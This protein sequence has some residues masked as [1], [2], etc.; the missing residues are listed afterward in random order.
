MDT[1]AGIVAFSIDESVEITWGQARYV[2]C[3]VMIDAMPLLLSDSMCCCNEMIDWCVFNCM[4]LRI[5]DPLTI[6]EIPP[7]FDN[8]LGVVSRPPSRSMM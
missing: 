8:A 7:K 3:D 2:S 5:H 1:D 6:G 4:H